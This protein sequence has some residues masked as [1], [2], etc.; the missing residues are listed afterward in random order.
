MDDKEVAEVKERI[1]KSEFNNEEE[2]LEII[3]NKE[4]TSNNNK[5][6]NFNKLENC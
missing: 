3:E 4:S 1:E 6:C 2:D 5:N